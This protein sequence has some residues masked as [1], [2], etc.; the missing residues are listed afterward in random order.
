VLCTQ[1]QEEAVDAIGPEKTRMHAS[2]RLAFARDEVSGSTKLSFSH[3]DPPLRVIRAFHTQENGALVHLHNVSGGLFGG[4]NLSLEVQVGRSAEVQLTTTGATR[5]YR[6]GPG[7]ARTRQH[8]EFTVL[9]GA[10]L[11]YVP[12]PIIP[13]AEANFCQRTVIRLSPGAGL[14]WWEILAPGREAKDEIFAFQRVEMRSDITA[15]DELICT[16]RMNLEQDKKP[17]GSSG[18]MGPYRYYATFNI[19]KVGVSAERWLEL[20]QHLRKVV[21][22]L[23]RVGDTLWGISTLKAHGLAVRCLAQQGCDVLSGVF[24]LWDAAKFALYGRHAI[25]PR[26]VY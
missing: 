21:Q 15:G 18:R 1:R 2:L 13:Y 23:S 3:Q 20:E 19:C 16:E 10:L 8:C 24:S 5:I 6:C 11:E 4:D 17:V 26:K 25:R 22:N 12:D 9:E 14:F 7:S